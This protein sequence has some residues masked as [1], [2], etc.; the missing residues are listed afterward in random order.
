LKGAE[1]EVGNTIV[2]GRTSTKDLRDAVEGS[3]FR[4]VH[5]IGKHLLVELS[6]GGWLTL[7]FGMTGEPMFFSDRPPRF[8][9]VTFSFHDGALAFGDPRMLGRVG[10]APSVDEFVHRKKLGPDALS[11]SKKD[12]LARFGKA[13]GAIKTALMDQHKLAGIGNLYADEVLFQSRLDP[14]TELSDLSGQDLETIYRNMKKVLRR[15]IANGT[16][17]SKFP[18]TYLLSHRRKGAP[19]PGC[20]GTTETI[21][22][23]GRAT[24]LCPPCQTRGGR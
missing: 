9:R 23:G 13:R 10:L 19:C 15:S 16:D 8:A 14:R 4:S 21:T 20:G 7:H 1:D 6:G 2:L 3:S 17:F 11:I 18:R 5:R 22:L 24:Y 12:F